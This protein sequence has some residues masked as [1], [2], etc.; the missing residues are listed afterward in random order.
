[1]EGLAGAPEAAPLSA[2][3]C[4]RT[5]RAGGALSGGAFLDLCSCCKVW[6]SGGGGGGVLG[7]GAA[8]FGL[9][10][11]SGGSGLSSGRVGL[12]QG[13]SAGGSGVLL[14]PLTILF[15][16]RDRAGAE[17]SRACSF[18]ASALSFSAANSLSSLSFSMALFATSGGDFFLGSRGCCGAGGGGE[19][20]ACG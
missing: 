1:M 9:V 20:A 17:R 15:L 5:N 19:L 14:A 10:G 16:D 11:R 2:S 12:N 4:S 3:S 8:L 18:S 6:C 13:C 7:L